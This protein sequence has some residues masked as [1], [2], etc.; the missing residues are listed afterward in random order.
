M[1][2]SGQL[3]SVQQAWQSLH[4]LL[5]C[6]P[7]LRSIPSSCQGITMLT[8]AQCRQRTCY[9]PSAI[10]AHAA[11]WATP[12]SSNPPVTICCIACLSIHAHCERPMP[13]FH[14]IDAGTV[15][16]AA[17]CKAVRTQRSGQMCAAQ[18][19]MCGLACSAE[20]FCPVSAA[21]LSCVGVPKF[22]GLYRKACA[23][24]HARANPQST[25]CACEI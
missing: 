20:K 3:S 12:V 16:S 7:T 10:N 24:G 5:H 11:F 22:P 18:K 25:P 23:Q 4:I 6:S 2:E 1:Q 17:G 8:Q 21:Q 19:S 13:E 15:Q 9:S 14:H